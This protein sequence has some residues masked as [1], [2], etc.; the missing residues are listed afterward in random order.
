MPNFDQNFRM[1]AWDE[2]GHFL[3][4]CF[5]KIAAKRP[6]LDEIRAADPHIECVFFLHFRMKLNEK[7]PDLA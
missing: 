5:F 3:N 4:H 7:K 6:F 2:K 1:E